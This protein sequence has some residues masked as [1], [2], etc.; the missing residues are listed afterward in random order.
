MQGKKCWGGE[1][2]VCDSERAHAGPRGSGARMSSSGGGGGG[3]GIHLA[4]CPLS[5]ACLSLN[6]HLFKEPKSVYKCTSE[7]NYR[8][9]L[10]NLVA[11]RT[12]KTEQE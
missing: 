7:A 3:E 5:W 1:A 6:Q 9:N 12:T 8:V 11:T 2:V 4:M 10:K